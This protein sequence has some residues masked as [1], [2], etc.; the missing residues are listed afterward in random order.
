MI[1]S[2]AEIILNTGRKAELMYTPINSNVL[3]K[4]PTEFI[5]GHN[6]DMNGFIKHL[7]NINAIVVEYQVEQISVEDII[8]RNSKC[9]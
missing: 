8:D 2:M 6:V 3:I 1:K 5:N 7:Q 9:K 4:I